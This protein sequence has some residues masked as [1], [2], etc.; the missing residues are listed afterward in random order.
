MDKRQFSSLYEN[1]NNQNTVG[2]YS[3]LNRFKGPTNGF[4]TIHIY[5]K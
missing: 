1:Y 3:P 2:H 5:I 4:L